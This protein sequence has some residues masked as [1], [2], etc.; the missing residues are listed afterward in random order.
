MRSGTTDEI[1]TAVQE[2]NVVM[3]QTPVKKPGDASFAAGREGHGGA[4]GL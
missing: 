4:G 3:T 1:S 2:G